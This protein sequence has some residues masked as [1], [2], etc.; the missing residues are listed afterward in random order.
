MVISQLLREWPPGYGG[1]ERVAHELASVW[2][3]DVF[4]L[5]VQRRR[6]G[7]DDPLPVTYSRKYLPSTKSLCRLLLPLPSRMLCG[8]ICSSEPLHGHLPSPGVAL[9][10]L[11][12]RLVNPRRKVTAHWHCFLERRSGFEGCLFVLYQW[13]ALR[14]IPH[15]SAV[16]TTS[17]RLAQELK[18]CG[19]RS[20]SVLV[21]PCSLTE[22][23]EQDALAL[24]LPVV[25][26]GDP[27]RVLFIGRL[28][29]YKRLDWL[30]TSLATLTSPWRLSVVGD[31]SKRDGFERLAQRLFPYSSPVSFH[32]RL[33]EHFWHC[34]VRGY[35]S[36]SALIGI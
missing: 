16:V 17:P 13:L 35:G 20:D 23:H 2:K 6:D 5:D 26:D 29:T 10:L 3:G 25:R 8:L 11:L 15:L 19:C 12:A 9:V 36:W 32:G 22:E 18:R 14:L 34:P 28:E 21:L 33:S 27:L 7:I 24:E 30:M 1:V 4:S 31:G